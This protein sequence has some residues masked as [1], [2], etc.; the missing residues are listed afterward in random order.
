MKKLN[1]TEFQNRINEVSKASKIF[2]PLTN[3]VSKAFEL[4]QEVLAEEKMEVFISTSTGGNRPQTPI[5]DYERPKCPTCDVEL[6]LRFNVE[7]IDGKKWNTSWFC[8]TCLT[9]YYS[10][11]TVQEWMNELQRRNVQEQ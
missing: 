1:Y 8:R 2:A 7:D 9:D 10:D 5:D 6:M 11:K 3:N 4:Y